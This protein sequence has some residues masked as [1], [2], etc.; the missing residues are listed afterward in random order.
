MLDAEKRLEESYL[1]IPPNAGNIGILT[2]TYL[3]TLNK[4]EQM[5][6][7]RH[8]SLNLPAGKKERNDIVIELTRIRRLSSSAK[9]KWNNFLV[10]Q[11]R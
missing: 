2:K 7:D 3:D 11:Q 6:Q 5:C 10:D 9:D 4:L 1:T 8:D